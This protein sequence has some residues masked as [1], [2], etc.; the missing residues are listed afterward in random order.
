M[1]TLILTEQMQATLAEQPAA[2]V[3]AKGT[4]AVEAAGPLVA[5]QARVEQPVAQAGG[6]LAAPKPPHPPLKNPRAL[7]GP[8]KGWGAHPG[9]GVKGAPAVPRWPVVEP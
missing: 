7:G 9:K 6:G 4:L 5:T 1:L 2:V 3:L 8:P